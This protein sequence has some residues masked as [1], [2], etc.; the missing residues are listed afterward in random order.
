MS[1]PNGIA[2]AELAELQELTA[3]LNRL[4]PQLA[5]ALSAAQLER[6]RLLEEIKRRPSLRRRVPPGPF[7]HI[8]QV[9]RWL[10][11]AAG[12]TRQ[13]LEYETGIADTT[14]RNIEMARHRPTVASMRKLLRHPAMSSLPEM[15]KQAGLSLRP[16]NNVP[17]AP[18]DAEHANP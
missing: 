6:D 16:R 14:I 12:L 4:L 7:T 13:Q 5:A 3:Q 9:V 18:Q 11:E 15:A 2:A 10:R 17:Q 8:G 1:K